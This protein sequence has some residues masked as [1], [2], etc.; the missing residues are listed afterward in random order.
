M[1]ISEHIL[2][3]GDSFI[4]ESEDFKIVNYESIEEAKEDGMEISE[5]MVE[6]DIYVRLPSWYKSEDNGLSYSHSWNI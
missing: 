5:D 4:K 6:E 1:N 3:E 2:I